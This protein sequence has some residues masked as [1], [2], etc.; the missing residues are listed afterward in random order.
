MNTETVNRDDEIRN[1]R[2]NKLMTLQEIADIYNLSRERVRQI[3]PR[4]GVKIWSERISRDDRMTE[5]ESL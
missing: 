4:D 5:E 1:L 2:Y 3:A